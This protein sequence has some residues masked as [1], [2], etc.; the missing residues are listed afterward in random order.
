MGV[1]YL[2]L[3]GCSD[4]KCRE[5]ENAAIAV[6]KLGPNGKVV[7]SVETAARTI[8]VAPG[9]YEVGRGEMAEESPKRVAVKAGQTV[10]VTLYS[11]IED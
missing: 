11:P 1:P 3:P 10:E 9:E 5:V 7:S 8:H 2:Q 4:T 6:D